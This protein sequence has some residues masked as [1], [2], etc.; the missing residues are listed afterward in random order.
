[1]SVCRNQ[2]RAASRPACRATSSRTV[3]SNS[4]ATCS[5][6]SRQT[7]AEAEKVTTGG[8]VEHEGAE[9]FAAFGWL[10]GPSARVLM[11][12][13][14]KKDGIVRAFAYGYL[15][16]ALYDPCE[17]IRMNFTGQKVRI[18]GWNL[19]AETKPNVRLFRGLLRH[20]VV[21]V[22]EADQFDELAASDGE[23]LV[24]RA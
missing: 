4:A 15:F 2:G 6:T 5:P 9:D 19:D 14:R 11:V 1:M 18:V 23:T 16:E 24:E 21:Y 10:R 17:G 22:K 7:H 20:R 8:A 13:F 12:E 3:A